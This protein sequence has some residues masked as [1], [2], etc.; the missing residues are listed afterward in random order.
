MS[1][2]AIKEELSIGAQNIILRGTRI[3]IPLSL[4]QKAIDIAHESHQG[5]SKTKAMIREKVWFP[6]IDD[7]VKATIDSCLA[8][9]ATGK[10][11]RP[12]PLQLSELPTK[13]W[14]KLHIDYYGPLPTGD[15]LV[16]IIDRYSRFPEVEVVSSTKASTLIHKLDRIFAVHGIPDKIQTDNGPPFNGDEFKRYLHILGIKHDR[17]TPKWPQANGEV[18]R[19][20]QPLG[21]VIQAAIVEGKPW[22]QEIQRFLMQYGITPHSVT[23]VPPCELLFNRQVKGKL[24]VIQR[25]TVTNRHREAM[26]N[27]RQ[28]QIHQKEYTDR[29]RQARESEIKVGDHVLV[30]QDRKNKFSSRFNNVPYV[31][32]S[33]KGTK[34][35]AENANKHQISRN[36]SHFKRFV[37]K[38]YRPDVDNDYDNDSYKRTQDRSNVH[39]AEPDRENQTQNNQRNQRLRRA[40]DRYG[41]PIPSELIRRTTVQKGEVMS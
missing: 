41:N 8:C 22:K 36:V 3:V 35:T 10:E 6:K 13:P 1:H 18:E 4:R 28:G 24:P 34:V 33:R 20:N 31:V 38:Q 17:S 19:F 26:A 5:M 2:R 12:E 27:E 32:I 29:R 30:K 37:A 11:N 25:K 15:Y 7:L 16:V 21:K 14:E 39:H 40:P 9:Q 23:K